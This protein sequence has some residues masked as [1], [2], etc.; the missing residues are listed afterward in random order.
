MRACHVVALVLA[1]GGLLAL[2]NYWTLP[3]GAHWFAGATP[4]GLG[5]IGLMALLAEAAFR[6]ADHPPLRRGLRVLFVTLG[7]LFL[8]TALLQFWTVGSGA[9]NQAATPVGSTVRWLAPPLV[10]AG[11]FLAAA[12]ALHLSPR[13][14]GRRHWALRSGL[15]G[16]LLAA[17]SFLGSFSDADQVLNPAVR[18]G[19]PFSALA[20]LAVGCGMLI[21]GGLRDWAARYLLGDS[22]DSPESPGE[23]SQQ[24]LM[25]VIAGSA[26]G[27]A[28]LATAAFV[29]W[30]VKAAKQTVGDTIKGVARAK[31]EELS[32]WLQERH[33]DVRVLL[34]M[35]ATKALLRGQGGR[36]QVLGVLQEMQRSFGYTSIAI[37]N[38]DRQVV[39]S[40]PGEFRA[41]PPPSL[42]TELQATD[43]PRVESDFFPSSDGDTHYD[44][45]GAVRDADGRLLGAVLARQ[46]VTRDLFPELR[47][48][49]VQSRTAEVVL[50][51]VE[52]DEAWVLTPLKGSPRLSYPLRV[53]VRS[54]SP[55]V[56][57]RALFLPS[58][59]LVQGVD[60]LGVP[61]IAAAQR[62]PD[63]N[64]IV[65]AK[66]DRAEA[67][68]AA[69]QRLLTATLALALVLGVVGLGVRLLWRQRQQR[70]IGQAKAAEAARREMAERFGAIM[71]QAND[72]ILLFDANQRIVDANPRA[73]QL[74][75]YPAE[76]FHRLKAED[77]RTPVHRGD[78][79]QHF[80]QALSEGI[81]FQT[82]HQRRDGAAFPVEVSSRAVQVGAA[83]FVL[84]IVRDVTERR[85]SEREIERLNRFYQLTNRILEAI[86]HSPN[87]EELFD[88]LCTLL[89]RSGGLRLAWVGWHDAENRSITP[90]AWCGEDGAQEYATGIR[91]SSDGHIPEGQG[92]S[93]TAFR[94]ARTMLCNDIASDPLM[95]PWQER[96]G[97][98]G[99]R[100]AL[101]LPLNCGGE[102]VG[103][104][105][106]YAVESDYFGPR[107]LELMERVVENVSFALTVFDRDDARRRAELALKT[108]RD[109]L[110]F[111]LSATT[112]VHFTL[113]PVSPYRTTF[114][115][116]NVQERLGYSPAE[117][118]S[119]PQAWLG[120]VHPDDLAHANQAMR[121]WD[122]QGTCAREY[123][124]RHAEGDYRWLR[125]EM[126]LVRDPEGKPHEI[127]GCWI[128]I[129][130][131]KEL[132]V[133]LE[134]SE[135]LYRLI[136]ENTTDAIWLYDLASS[137]FTYMSPS[138]V[139]LLG[140]S[141]EELL[142]MRIDQILTPACA[143]R[144]QER[145]AV[146][147]GQALAGRGQVQHHSEQYEH[148]RRDG[149]IAIG[150]VVTSIVFDERHQ[151]VAVL[152]VT[153][154]VTQRNLAE[155]ELRKLSL[156]VEQNPSSIVITDL[157]GRI[158]YVNP[159][160]TRI[161]GYT[162][163][164]VRGKNPRLLKSGLNPPETYV[165]MWDAITQGR[166]WRG[167]LINRKKDGSLHT[168]MII[169]TA[170]TNA[171]GRP[172]HYIALKEDNSDRKHAENEL[173]KL[174]RAVEQA[175]L[176]IVITDLSG[177]IEYVNPWFT[178][179]T[180][181]TFEEVRGRNPRVLKS[182]GTPNRVYTEMWETLGRGETWRGELFNRKKNGEVYC[183]AAVIAPIAGSDGRATH[184]VAIKEDIT[185]RKRAEDALR[186][187]E[188]RFRDL[189]DLES[190]T[191]L[192]LEADSGRIL[193]ANRAASELYGY[194]VERLI[195]M[196]NTDLSA[197]PEKTLETAPE[198]AAQ[199]DA[200]VQIPTRLHRKSDG[201]VFPVD[202]NLRFFRRDNQPYY[203]A[204]IRDVTERKR[205]EEALHELV[206]QL[207]ALHAVSTALQQTDLPLPK[208]LDLI[209]P[210]LPWAL[211]SPAE[212]AAIVSV[213]E[214]A[215][216]SGDPGDFLERF[217]APIVINGREAGR[218]EVG[219][220]RQP[221]PISGTG[222]EARERETIE[223]VARTLSL[224]LGARES[225]AAVQRFN[226]E[227]EQRVTLRTEELAA[228]N[229]EMAALLQ[230]IP[231]MVVRARQD[232]T[233]VY[234]QHSEDL[235]PVLRTAS[236]ATL[237]PEWV[238]AL[239]DAGRQAL[240]SAGVTVQEFSLPAV[241]A[242]PALF[243][244]L[245]AAP[246]GGEEFVV[247]VR[248]ITRRKN[249]EAETVAMLDR[250]RQVSEMKTRFISVA[251]HEFRTPMA[252][253][254]GSAELLRNHLDRLNPA[255]R[256]E[257]FER[258]NVSLQRMTDMLDEILTL[259]RIDAGR[260]RIQ[261]GPVNLV[262][263]A[264]TMI[265]EIRLGDRES[266]HLVLQV[267]GAGEE[268]TTDSNLL[269]HILSNLLTNAA[270]YSPPGTEIR[271]TLRL[272]ADAVEF[273]V[274]DHGIGIPPADLGRIFDAFERASNVGNIKGTGLGL[275]I[276]KRMSE[277]LGG[278]ISVE[279]TLQV[280]S[281]FIVRLPRLAPTSL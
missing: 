90:V 188:A 205:A 241:D 215:V 158:E 81:V 17:V 169:I 22:G 32:H 217:A 260:V 244:E 20:F 214:V 228:R 159:Q 247:F 189:F 75:G 187:S 184:Y 63:T 41:P 145:L 200:V 142:T 70:L 108:G 172:T 243:L 209:V 109:R 256:E 192:L 39:A 146:L 113:E 250:E 274:L 216:R 111:I 58:G 51:R 15:V 222:I 218:V 89:V 71:Q 136:A 162:A 195:G 261:T 143:I 8:L 23:K 5:V 53:E 9:T 141:R 204:A 135:Q 79:A 173:R 235:A 227:L 100:A 281:R 273:D 122:R 118:L 56:G 97:A 115:S 74:Y 230:S 275:N 36:E 43:R 211:R 49:P 271:V 98:H 102:P 168:E 4:E 238:A 259:S 67:M 46:E 165:E 116:G 119:D 223:G 163:E 252:A 130:A 212:A 125:D 13:L 45:L 176:S 91:V 95:G 251:S 220:V 144:A 47:R 232:G 25:L 28:L 35:D 105:T 132:A 207:R 225:F 278:S 120:R 257:L 156:A 62:L 248:D 127:V 82:E 153:R 272:H 226:A 155:A 221:D 21:G 239:T 96:A 12:L 201:T 11:F 88:E 106:V 42:W 133:Q 242:Q 197:E 1:G 121:T 107:L 129:T 253:V 64:L 68:A 24:V 199:V 37:Y 3:G 94:Q 139:R 128:D 171:Q 114:I 78:T 40:S 59:T 264:H 151:P 150:E 61:A 69:R 73:L 208:L 66:M 29:R 10:W 246:V 266:H 99:L 101:A 152:G 203:L 83:R 33:G 149:S 131:S 174:S 6:W 93:G 233:I 268:I 55:V 44:I 87:R 124:F 140:Y 86:V 110:D 2:A 112:A 191:I 270:R 34:R 240:A 183:E 38:A 198:G 210:H 85:A 164:E 280:G 213:D 134:K 269:R 26:L 18:L 48:W 194:P 254:L 175:P 193:Q 276:V 103:V 54:D 229:R 182:G 177:A 167:E 16:T 180:G 267:E 258:I 31:A 7:A 138:S 52:P 249:V 245:R 236:P 202:M 206:K 179:L 84:S 178:R 30:E 80:A 19:D 147:V 262:R 27:M 219:Y 126:R 72:A 265:D 117:F 166:P 76:E 196:R 154:D 170:V 279:S 263:L 255:K 148:L 50:A 234:F 65:V 60:A 277:L 92:P 57:V 161:T 186:E 185:D 137:R 123:R 181:Y 224:G 231:D 14:A 77:L 190:D 104:L 160:F 237:P 157:E